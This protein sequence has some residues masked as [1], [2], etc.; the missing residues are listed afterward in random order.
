MSTSP[1]VIPL[2]ADAETLFARLRDALKTDLGLAGAG[3][4]AT[5]DVAGHA[6]PASTSAGA[7]VSG[8]GQVQM[9]GTADAQ[10]PAFIGIHTGGAWLAARLHAEL[11]LA[12]PLGFLSSAFYR[13]DVQA[14]GL[15]ARM[16][17]TKIDFDV[18]GRDI[19]LVDDILHT[20]RT[21]RAALN[22]IFDYGRPARVR[23]AVLLDRGGREL[24]VRADYLGAELALQPG[25]KLVLSQRTS[26]MF[27]LRVERPGS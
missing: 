27:E 22:E 21:I 1:S 26:G 6:A 17:P 4:A 9:Q 19:V 24:P 8:Q 12:S 25:E 7:S 18:N 20:G 3:A 15:S 13:D 2:P 14:R 11:G 16:Q 10:A 5:T 23:L